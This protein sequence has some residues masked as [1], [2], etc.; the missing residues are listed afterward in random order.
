MTAFFPWLMVGATILLTTFGQL[1]L[2]WQVSIPATPPFRF[3]EDWPTTLILL[4]RP[5]VIAA[6]ASAFLA[7]LC[8]MAAVSRLE[9]SK[10]YPFMAL[11]FLLV[12]ALAIP[13]FGESLTRGKLV[14]IALVIAGLIALSRG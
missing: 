4:M 13:L 8:W 5:W 11:N 2:K 14:G 12:G 7:S 1:V 10:A 3:M 6:L 9:L